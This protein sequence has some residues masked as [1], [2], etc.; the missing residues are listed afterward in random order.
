MRL[1]AGRRATNQ[2][3]VVSGESGAGKTETSKIMLRFASKMFHDPCKPSA[4]ARPPSKYCA[5]TVGYV[6][7]GM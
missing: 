1:G 2:S 5:F 3:I 4:I 7:G 6:S